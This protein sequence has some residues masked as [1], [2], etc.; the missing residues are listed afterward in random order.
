MKPPAPVKPGPYV[1]NVDGLAR[2]IQNLIK[3]KLT[4]IGPKV[5][6]QAIVY[7]Q[8]ESIDDL[9]QYW[10]DEQ[11]PGYYRIRKTD[12]PKYFNFTVGPNS[13]KKYLHPP[14]I[15]LWQA[16][17]QGSSFSLIQEKKEH[18]ALAF[19]GVRSCELEAM[20]IQDPVFRGEHFTDSHY[21][22]T[23]KRAFILAVNCGRANDTCFC[24]SMNSGPSVR[25]GFD[26]ALTEFFEDDQ[27]RFLLEIG[28]Q[29]GE[30]ILE[31]IPMEKAGVDHRALCR[32]Q[33]EDTCEQI[34]LK[35][36]TENLQTTLL[37]NPNH[38]RWEEVANR[39][40]SC[41]NCTMVCPTCFCTTVEDTTDLTGNHA[42]RWRRWDSCFTMDF[43]YVAGG[44]IRSSTKSR[45]RQW[46]T[47][48]LATWHNQFGTSGCVGCGRCITWC[49]VGIDI[50]EEAAA[51]QNA[52]LTP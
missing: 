44:H 34:S 19:I 17:R 37:E 40:L 39:C 41:G 47:H 33:Y 26:L 7:G 2:V 42:E 30:K 25:D 49:P 23:R 29:K 43:S 38:P 9:P 5:E 3:A 35:L 20:K 31:N 32:E 21:D 45:Y 15:R 24:T 51:I 14:H 50:T 13:W 12:N 10:Q 6:D 22:E 48:K 36:E 52:S 46:M 8:I 1:I 4:V 16:E 11:A 18:N 28:S 27:H